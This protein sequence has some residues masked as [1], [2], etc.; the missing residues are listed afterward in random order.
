MVLN[1]STTPRARNHLARWP[2]VPLLDR[3]GAISK[4][5]LDRDWLPLNCGIPQCP[6]EGFVM[7][8]AGPQPG[9]HKQQAN[10]TAADL[11]QRAVHRRA[12]DAAIWGMPA[13]NYELM[14]HEM[15]GKLEGRY[16]QIV[17]WSR[18]LDW[19]NQTLTPHSHL[20][21]QRAV[22]R[23]LIADSRTANERWR[24]S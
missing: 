17:Y 20:Y 6:R 13:V 24:L 4:T 1:R 14:Y 16:N 21:P 10:V 19:K 5:T 7:N 2:F 11:T 18:L 3:K 22:A 23:S 12:V 8:Q 9:P 15:V